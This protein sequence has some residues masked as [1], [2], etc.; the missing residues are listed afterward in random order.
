MPGITPSGGG[1]A[2]SAGVWTQAVA[3]TG[4]TDAA[5]QG[6]SLADFLTG[7]DPKTGA[8]PAPS[9]QNMS[10]KQIAASLAAI[11]R[12]GLTGDMSIAGAT[13][14]QTN[15]VEAALRAGY[16]PEQVAKGIF[17]KKAA[18]KKETAAQKQKAAT[19]AAE[20]QIQEV[21]NNPWTRMADALAQQ[22][23]GALQTLAPAV[24]G[25]T[26]PAAEAGAANQALASLGLS[27]GSSAGQWLNAQ[28]AA[29]QATA[30]PVAQ[31]M[32]AEGAQYAAEAG[33]ITKAVMDWGQANAIQD[34]TAPEA[35]WL[36]A[37]ASHVTSNLSYY[38]QVP[39]AALPSL[40][41]AVAKALQVSGGYGGA[42]GA[43]TTPIQNIVAGSAGGSK[44][45]VPGAGSI[46]G[47]ASTGAIPAPAPG[48]SAG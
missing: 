48:G 44:A 40:S 16:S 43:G 30:A 25:A 8:K 18:A 26:G 28:T 3:P 20:R 32:A 31:A 7:L 14:K 12:S 1:G 21:Q 47:T 29:A 2:P 10:D 27:S 45:G 39:T 15:E 41:P 4:P 37:L 11:Q 6:T 42:A 9:V 35:G 23:T 22:S 46:T 17:P 33:P 5:A 34:I 19:T 13:P 36:N 24:S 38:G